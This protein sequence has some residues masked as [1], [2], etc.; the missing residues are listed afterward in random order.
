MNTDI[1]SKRCGYCK[2]AGKI[3]KSEFGITLIACPICK[4]IGTINVPEDYTICG[5]CGGKGR[6]V[7][8]YAMT[9]TAICDVCKGKGWAKPT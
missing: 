8:G 7:G 4:T 2:G 3:K 1:T 5:Q 6:T 9:I